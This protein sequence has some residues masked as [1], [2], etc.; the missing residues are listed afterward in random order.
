[1][2]INFIFNWGTNGSGV[3]VATSLAKVFERFY[4][5]PWASCSRLFRSRVFFSAVKTSLDL[6][7]SVGLLV[8]LLSDLTMV[9]SHV[10]MK[11]LDVK[12][13]DYEPNAFNF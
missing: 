1:M 10:E 4:L 2:S 3:Y 13:V 8:Y 11:A 7:G 6:D 12:L 5:S 9:R